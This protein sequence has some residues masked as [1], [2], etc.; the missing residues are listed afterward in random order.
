MYEDVNN[1][2][3]KD[4]KFAKIQA[5]KSKGERNSAQRT[6]EEC[7]PGSPLLQD[8]PPPNLRA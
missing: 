3:C 5:V 6:L 2:A 4:G 8:K 1:I 7:F